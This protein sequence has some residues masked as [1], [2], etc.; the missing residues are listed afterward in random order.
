MF[1]EGLVSDVIGPVLYRNVF[2]LPRMVRKRN[3]YVTSSMASASLS[4]LISYRTSSPNW[5]K[6]GP[7]AGSSSGMKFERIVTF[8]VSTG[9]TNAYRSV[10]SATGSF[11]IVGASRWD[12]IGVHLA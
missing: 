10:L 11:E 3:W 6:F 5:K 2:G 8:E 12:D 1:D 7:P 4:I 9:S